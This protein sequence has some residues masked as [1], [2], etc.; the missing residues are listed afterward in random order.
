[1]TTTKQ[2]VTRAELHTI[3]W[4]LAAEYA[5]QDR[6]RLTPQARLNHDLGADSLTI[7]E[8][9]LALEERLGVTI[10]DEALDQPDL[11][12]GQIEEALWRQR[13]AA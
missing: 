9:T 1:M 3:L 8:L 2:A 13:E 4:D 12:L 11:T 10:P 7:T 6:A 5:G